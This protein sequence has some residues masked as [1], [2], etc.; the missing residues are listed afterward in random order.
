[1]SLLQTNN[2]KFKT[3]IVFIM[4]VIFLIGLTFFAKHLES[5]PENALDLIEPKLIDTIATDEESVS[6]LITK[7]IEIYVDSVKVPIAELE[8]KLKIQFDGHASPTILLQAEEGTPISNAVKIMDI[9]NKNQY[10]VILK[11][12]PQ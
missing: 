8:E 11:V 1:M 5:M 4:G 6:I 2:K 7:E 3:P 9:A 12:R 10:K